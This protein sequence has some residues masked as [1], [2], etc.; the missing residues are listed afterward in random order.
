MHR[1][2]ILLLAALLG[3]PATPGPSGDSDG[4]NGPDTGL[5]ESAEHVPADPCGVIWYP[6]M[7][8]DGF[9]AEG[10]G[11]P[12]C[13]P[14]PGW[15]AAGGDC[16]DGDGRRHPDAAERCNGL[17]DDCDGD[18]DEDFPAVMAPSWP[19]SDGDGWGRGGG[20]RWT[21]DLAE[22]LVD[23]PGDCHDGD[24]SIHPGAREPCDGQDDDCDG[25][26][27][28]A[29]LGS[30]GDGVKGGAFE[31]CDGDDD[32]LCPG[33]CS[34]HCACPSAEPGDLRVHF[35]DVGQGDST[36]VISPDG[37]TML[38]DAGG[39]SACGDLRAYLD[40]LGVSL[41]YTLVS[42]QHSDHHGSM[43][44]VLNEHS[45]A[46]ACFDN[47]G[48][49]PTSYDQAYFHAAAGRRVSLSPGDQIDLGPQL[50]VDV[51]HAESGS[52]NEN[53]NS[54]VLM[55]GFDTFRLILGG[56]CESGCEAGLGVADVD[57]YK[58]HHH[59]SSDASSESLLSALEPL[60][61]LISVGLGNAYGH[62]TS[63]TLYRLERYGVDVY[64]TDLDGD[65]VLVSDGEGFDFAGVSYR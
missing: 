15:V 48:D 52:S 25:E 26:V 33:G 5:A 3:C 24:G 49:F 21:C 36:L 29:C 13:A 59:G 30:C 63:S 46:V 31:A 53:E 34:D 42:H 11:L 1:P 16:S 8:G 19:D 18:A 7:D 44:D 60:V 54:V 40:A 2:S 27:D 17:D 32:A 22:G 20:L 57:V 45:E 14:P 39:S 6:D 12:S 65:V 9:G 43:D 55:L 47:G 62:P 41:D 64:R 61:A 50:Q 10:L 23:R 38:V 58:V 37:F 51:L 28:E 56:D 35:I 4:S